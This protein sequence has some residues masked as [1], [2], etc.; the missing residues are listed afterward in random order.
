MKLLSFI[1]LMLFLS[2]NGQSYTIQSY[3]MDNGLPQNSIKDIVKDRYGFIWLSME[4]RVVRY[5][6]SRFTQYNNFKFEN[7]SFGDFYGNIINDRITIFNDSEKD[8]LLISQRYPHPASSNIVTNP[9]TTATTHGK[10]GKRLVKNNITVRF[11]SYIDSYFIQLEK[12]AYYFEN[13]SIIYVDQKNKKETKVALEFSRNR[14]K[15]LFV[16]GEYVFIADPEKKQI[17]QLYQG[18]YSYINAPSLYTDPDTKVYWQQ[19][20]GQVFMINHGK[21]YKSQFSDGNLKLSYV[22]EYKE[23][24]KEISGAMFYDEVFNKLYIGSSINGLKILSLSDFSV[25]VKNLPYQD[26]VCYASI[27]YGNSSILTQEGITY[28]K[29]RSE[30]LYKVPQSYDKRYIF[31][32][33]SGNLVYRENN[34]I[35]VRY[36]NTGFTKY[37]SISFKEKE[38]DGIYKSGGLYMASVVS[39]KQPYLYLFSHD[40]FNKIER[41]I[42][43]HDNIDTVLRYNE[44]LLYLGGSSGV[45]VFSLSQNKVVEHIGK[46]LPVKQ[47]IQTGDGN[48]W[49]TTYNRGIYL[50]K[51]Q[52][53]IKLPVDKNNFLAN[54]HYLLEDKNSNVWISSDNGLFRVNK[55]ILL[56]YMEFQKGIVTY[57]R[58]TKD[59]GFLNNEFNGSAYPCG[60]ILEDGQFVFPSMAGFVFF[61]PQNVK[62][63]YP[64]TQD[65]YLEKAR[66]K[67]QIVQIGDKLLL[68]PG[69]KNADIYIDLPYYADLENI[70]LQAKLMGGEDNQWVNIKNDKTF[71]LANIEPGKYSLQ[72]RFLSS[73]GGK[74]VYKSLSVEIEAYFYQTL[75]FRILIVGLVMLAFV[76]I[77][78]IRTNF[79]RLKNKVLKNTLVHRDRELKETHNKLKNESDYQKKLIESISHDIT[80]P[81]KFI[82]LLSQELYESEDP[83]NQKKYFDSI[84]KTSEQLY[85]FTLSLKEYTELYKQ[86]NTEEEEHIIHD[87]IEAKKLLFEEIAAR[88]NTFIYNFCDHHASTTVN[89]NIL[90][91]IFHN[92]ID[93][94]V[95]NTT[96]G[97]IVITSSSTHSH[98][99]ICI[100][101]TGSG[102]SDDQRTYYFGLFHKKENLIFKNYG[103]GL[104]M[105]VQLMM[106]IDSEMTFHKNTPKGTIIKI[107]IKI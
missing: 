68:K 58:Y 30:R 16:H 96:D 37:D 70:Y 81:V 64:G 93:N 97:E 89:K 5:D 56:R 19:I 7:L 83:K 12:G 85:K 69:Y 24:D 32:D 21:I 102:M 75:T 9:N 17:L 39:G 40:N 76:I 72:I 77:L 62:T 74:F 29:D 47:I 104:H 3:N 73:E 82:S 4:G 45:D 106:K 60:H 59:H 35:H 51:N 78:Q 84:Y 46:G 6:G 14:L 90:L 99:E 20:S 87:L 8:G 13:N 103:L 66:V 25:S 23:I 107:I 53:A 22:L 27:P 101:D 18:K 50:I 91:A 54:A 95:K 43:C 71:R 15:R 11:V 48:I 63:Y 31:R 10:I 52:K 86:K 57:Y 55:N 61:T 98:L 67:G 79:L 28:Y 92:I 44:D 36:K 105:V 65:I 38:I 2:V 33:N 26:E 100:A 42:P 94:A 80:T 49:F 34:S 88:K 1:L 41:R